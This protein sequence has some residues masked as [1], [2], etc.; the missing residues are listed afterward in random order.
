MEHLASTKPIKPSVTIQVTTGDGQPLQL[1]CCRL[2]TTGDLQLGYL[3]GVQMVFEKVTPDLKSKTQVLIRGDTK[4]TKKK[5]KQTNEVNK[6]RA[7]TS[8]NDV[9]YVEPMGGVTRK[10]ATPGGKVEV[11]MEERLANLT[12]DLKSRGKTAVSHNLTKLLMQALH[13]KDQKLI[14]TVLQHNKPMVALQT[15]SA[16][17]ADYVLQL[18]QQLA[19]MSSRK[20]S[21]CAAVCTWLSAVLRCHSALILASANSQTG[22]DKLTH[23]LAVFTHRRSHLCQLLNLKGRLDL[24]MSQRQ[25][26]DSQVDQQPI[27]E[28]NDTSSDESEMEVERAQSDSEHSWDA[29]ESDGDG[30]DGLSGADDGQSDGDDDANSDDGGGD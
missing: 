8:S 21:Q 13:S 30:H 5:T 9:T 26:Q 4:E 29:N 3:H 11:P 7:D 16:L 18:L 10:R 20:T 24:T 19:D 1:Q 15:V 22:V 14:Q 2:P 27:L 6:V 17:P 25:G 12:V 23:L 28:Y